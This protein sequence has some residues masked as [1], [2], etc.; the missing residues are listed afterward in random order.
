M[1]APDGSPSADA[2]LLYGP[3]EGSLF[4]LPGLGPGAL[5]MFGL[6]KG[7]GLYFFAEVLAG[8]LTGSGTCAGPDDTERRQPGNGMLSI[9]MDVAQ[10][11]D[12]DAFS[13]DV[14]DYARFVKSARPAQ[15]GREVLIPGEKEQRMRAER[16]EDGLPLTQEVLDDILT[17]ARHVGMGEEEIEALLG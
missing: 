15:E 6:Y 13:K 4:P 11:Q 2:S 9:F 7:S 16:L 17:T 10:F 12:M 8:A 1:V 5:A 3:Q 14:L